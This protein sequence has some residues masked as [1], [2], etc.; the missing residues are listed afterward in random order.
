[1]DTPAPRYDR[2]PGTRPFADHAADQKLFFGRDREIHELLHQLLSTHLLVLY[3]KS[4]LGKTSLLQAGIAPRLRER[5]F[6]P[7]P[8]RLNDLEQPPLEVFFQAIAE[9]CQHHDIDY[10]PGEMSSLWEFFKTV[11]FLRGEAL[12]L[13][14]LVI[15]QFEELFT[16]QDDSRRAVMAQELADLTSPRLPEKIRARRRA[17]EALPYSDRPPEVKIVLVIREDYLGILQE[18]TGPMP[19]ILTQR[20]RLPE[21]DEQQART[22][23]EAPAQV[24][25]FWFMRRMSYLNSMRHLVNFETVRISR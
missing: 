4:G 23:M 9:Q 12:Q 1:M 10:T 8:I 24:E 5:D 11:L 22:A 2:Y 7:L 17:G 6:L 18:L 15:D 16:L 25:T 14:V 13:P 3:G 19:A 20:Y 21:F